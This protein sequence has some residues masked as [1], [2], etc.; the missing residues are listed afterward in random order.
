MTHRAQCS[1]GRRSGLDLLRLIAAAFVFLQH[2]L[3][4]CQLEDWIDLAGFSVGRIGTAIFFLLAG[5][6][7]ASSA[8]TP[9]NWFRNRLSTLFPTFW[10]VTIIG[11]CVAGL[12]GVKVF[13]AWQILCQML[14]VGY[15]THGEHMVNVATWFMSPLLL[16]YLA[17]TVSRMTFPRALPVAL[18]VGF[19][20]LAVLSEPDLPVVSCH[21]V[22][23]FVAYLIG[24]SDISYQR[25]LAAV[26]SVAWIILCRFQPE[27]RYGAVAMSALTIAL[28]V[29]A[30]IPLTQGF[31]RIAYEWFLVHGLCI[32]IAASGSHNPLLMMPVAVVGSVFAASALKHLVAWLRQV[33]SRAFMKLSTEV[34]SVIGERSTTVD[35]AVGLQKA[36]TVDLESQPIPCGSGARMSPTLPSQSI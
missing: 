19:C 3:N 16:L 17:V 13:D 31:G 10:V 28:P 12:T 6:L 35:Q 11:F 24:R 21:A 2:A 25:R 4:N 18:A 5:L 23:F 30:H 29:Q 33:V 14:A 20:G 22:T 7:A 9:L 8:R 1:A 36:K 34:S 26:A 27:F 15:F 32:K